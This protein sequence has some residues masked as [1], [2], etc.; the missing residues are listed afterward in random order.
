MSVNPNTKAAVLKRLQQSKR[1]LSP[2]EIAN[3]VGVFYPTQDYWDIFPELVKEGE[4]R[5]AYPDGIKCVQDT[6]NHNETY[7]AVPVE[8]TEEEKQ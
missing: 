8:S 5:R 1:L 4:I 2:S 6:R 3:D 7:E